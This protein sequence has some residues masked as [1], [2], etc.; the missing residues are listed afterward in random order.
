MLTSVDRDDIPDGGSGHF[1]ETVKALKVRKLWN[2]SNLVTVYYETLMRFILT[3]S[4]TRNANLR[5]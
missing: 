5:L 1:A 3:Y 2:C 4:N